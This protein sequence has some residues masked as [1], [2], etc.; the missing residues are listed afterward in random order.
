MQILSVALVNVLKQG[1]ERVRRLVAAII[2]YIIVGLFFISFVIYNGSIVVGDKS[3]HS[4]T[5]HFPQLFYYALIATVFSGPHF[6]TKIKQFVRSVVINW[7]SYILVAFIVTIVIYFNSMAHPYLLADNRHY[8]FYI[9]K[10]LLSKSEL[11]ILLV[12][13][14]LYGLYCI[15]DTIR[16]KNVAFKIVYWCC[17]TISLVP[18]Q[19]LEFRYYIIPYLIFRLQMKPGLPWQFV[20]ESFTSIV[21][22][23]VTVYLFVTKTFYWPDSSRPQRIIWWMYRIFFLLTFY[24]CQ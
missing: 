17:V 3:A 4:A 24:I 7:I 10:R 13:W 16:Y 23:L 18:Q 14:Y 22:N 20:M 11:K 12:P 1:T 6:S 15:H 21:V 19:L 8:T 5:V 9:W 2:G